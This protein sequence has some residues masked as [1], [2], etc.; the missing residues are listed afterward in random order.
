VEVPDKNGN[1]TG[2]MINN[3][4]AENDT[5]END[6]SENGIMDNGSAAVIK[7]N[8]C[9]IYMEDDPFI[10][11]IKL[12]DP[13]E[14]I[15]KKVGEPTHNKT[16]YSELFRGD[17]I[18]SDYDFGSIM[19]IPN[20]KGV[21]QAHSITISQEG[22]EGPRGIKVGDDIQIVLDKYYLDHDIN[23]A[24]ITMEDSYIYPSEYGPEDTY[25]DG[26]YHLYKI[27]KETTGDFDSQHIEGILWFDSDLSVKGIKYIYVD[28]SDECFY[29]SALRFH[30][31]DDKV[32]KIVVYPLFDD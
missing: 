25:Y 22:F 7:S 30:I 20:N 2:E 15:N 17:E 21:H 19:F 29:A 27:E 23:F 5:I 24:N 10:L 3:V 13:M 8:I 1:K 12:Y 16:V 31:K 26:L 4:V 28:V 18:Y 14:E 9:E 6:I 32:S 11:D